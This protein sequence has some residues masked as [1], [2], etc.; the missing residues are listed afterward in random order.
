[1]IFRN[2]K[3]PKITT[4]A[5]QSSTYLNKIYELH[6]QAASAASETAPSAPAGPRIITLPFSPS[7]AFSG[8]HVTGHGNSSNVVSEQNEYGLYAKSV[9]EAN[10]RAGQTIYDSSNT[11]QGMTATVFVLPQA[12][13]RIVNGTTDV[14][15][16]LLT[17]RAATEEMSSSAR[18]FAGEI[19]SVG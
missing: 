2:D 19:V 5:R 16:A 14:T 1:M 12:A 4:T 7:T 8:S 15:A 10:D 3:C 6:T 9:V 17:F 11:V 13:P 18:G